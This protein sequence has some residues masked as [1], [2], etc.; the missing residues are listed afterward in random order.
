M[1]YAGSF[2]GFVFGTGARPGASVAQLKGWRKKRA[3]ITVTEGAT[4]NT[5]SAPRAS[6]V[7]PT[8]ELNLHAATEAELATLVDQAMEAFTPSATPLPLVIA[9][10]QRWVQVVDAEPVLAPEWP[11]A[12]VTTT[13]VAT[14]VAADPV[15]YAA[16]PTTYTKG[17]AGSSWEFEATNAGAEVPDALRAWSF[18]ITAA[19]T[20][21]DPKI[22]VDH[23]DGSFEQV[24]FS[25]LTMT[26][27]QVLT[28]SELIPRVGSQRA[29]GYIRSLTE[30]GTAG[31]TFRAWRL[32]DSTGSDERN[33]VSVSAASGT[34]TGSCSVRG[35]W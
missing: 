35:T 16:T 24:T 8:L 33:E 5:T 20:L 15:L 21:V 27:G 22:R 14:F 25:G 9:G 19:S 13:F 31:R 34:F 3:A 17:S 30:A 2:N 18:T 32:L 10:R 23:A 7:E 29:S 12:E 11:G 6:A 4:R 1:S 26:T 28:V